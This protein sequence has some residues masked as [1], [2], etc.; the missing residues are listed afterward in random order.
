M[1]YNYSDQ[2]DSSAKGLYNEKLLLVNCDVCPYKLPADVWQDN[3]GSW[4]DLQFGDVYSH[5]VESPGK[6]SLHGF[7]T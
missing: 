3:L 1:A 4:S 7:K 5:L 6:L 2:L